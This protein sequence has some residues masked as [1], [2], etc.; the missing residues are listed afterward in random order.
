MAYQPKYQIVD[1]PK[2]VTMS[3]LRLKLH[4]AFTQG[5]ALLVAPNGHSTG[6]VSGA[7]FHVA[8]DLGLKSHT[9]RMEAGLLVWASK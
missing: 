3:P 8:K 1:V 4:E 5:K 9:R 7:A 2:T 6:T